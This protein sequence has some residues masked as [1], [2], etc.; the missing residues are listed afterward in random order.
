MVKKDIIE[1]SIGNHFIQD[2]VLYIVFKEGAD[3]CID[4]M[5]ESK[6]ARLL[7]QN[8]QKMKILVDSRGL[9]N[10]TKE[11][12]DYAAED[13]HAD[14]S[15]AMALVSDSLPTKLMMNFFIKFNRPKTP[16]KMFTDV[17]KALEWLNIH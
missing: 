5:K 10:I 1:T 17:D 11:A 8:N 2:D 13:R 16:T 3:V 6:K 9:F 15:I 12:R 7:L 14:L 4:C